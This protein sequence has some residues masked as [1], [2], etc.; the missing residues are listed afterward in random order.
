MAASKICTEG[1]RYL[2]SCFALISLARHFDLG[3][4]KFVLRRLGPKKIVLRHLGPK[5]TCCTLLLP[6][7]HVVKNMHFFLKHIR[8]FLPT[9]TS[10]VET[11][12]EKFDQ[13][14]VTHLIFFLGTH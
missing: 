10:S 6:K 3:P 12:S 5:K 13:E 14:D 11:F 1:P 8:Y 2:L 4:K 9:H 7:I